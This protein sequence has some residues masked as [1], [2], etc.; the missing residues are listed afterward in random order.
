MAEAAEQW[1]AVAEARGGAA[2]VAVAEAR[3][4]EQPAGE[5]PC[6]RRELRADGGRATVLGIVAARNGPRDGWL[7]TASKRRGWRRRKRTALTPTMKPTPV[8]ASRCVA[9]TVAPLDAGPSSS[10]I[11]AGARVNRLGRMREGN[12]VPLDGTTPCSTV[13]F[14]PL[15]A[16][17]LF[18]DADA[19]V[20]RR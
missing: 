11:Q 9:T 1:A 10:E 15:P 18:A 8:V 17:V 16:Y 4:R 6:G 13:S 14:S 7:G 20:C 3:G 19:N 2:A 5:A 12:R